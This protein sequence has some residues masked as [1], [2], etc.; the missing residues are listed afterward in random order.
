[1]TLYV[2]H[3]LKDSPD[4]DINLFVNITSRILPGWTMCPQLAPSAKINAKY[5]EWVWKK[6][7]PRK[8]KSF[9]DMYQKELNYPIKRMFVEGIVK[10]IKE[11]KTVA[12]ACDCRDEKHCHKQIIAEWVA[13]HGIEVVQGSELRKEKRQQPMT[14]TNYE[15]LTFRDVGGGLL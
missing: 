8:W 5:M 1:M 14:K 10:R 4:Q 3:A 13:K 15:Q 7:W 12:I 2:Y 6:E 9:R 11:G